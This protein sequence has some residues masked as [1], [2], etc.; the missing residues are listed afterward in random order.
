MVERTI[1]IA[2]FLAGSQ[3][4]RAQLL[5]IVGRTAEADR[6]IERAMTLWPTHRFVRF[7]RFTILAFTGRARAALAML[8]ADKAPQNFTAAGIAL[9]RASLPA[10]YDPSPVNIATARTANREKGQADLSLASQAVMNLSVLGDI[11][12]AFRVIDALYATD[13]A[14]GGRNKVRGTSIAWRF[15]PWLFVPPVAAVRADPRFK[16]LC[17]G[18]GLTDYWAKRGIKPDYQ[19]RDI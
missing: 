18:I 10:L 17:D 8:E 16:A 4:P 2:P 19:I 6:V 5:W 3:Y 15:A 12:G 14:S 13:V 11:D 1:T 9:W 7:A